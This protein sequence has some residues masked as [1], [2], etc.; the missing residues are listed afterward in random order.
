[1]QEGKDDAVNTSWNNEEDSNTGQVAV[2]RPSEQHGAGQC[3]VSS[4]VSRLPTHLSPWQMLPAVLVLVTGSYVDNLK[5]TW[6]LRAPMSILLLSFH[7]TAEETED[8]CVQTYS[9]HTTRCGK[10]GFVLSGIQ[11]EFSMGPV[12]QCHLP[13]L[14]KLES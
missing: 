14:I 12:P 5:I 9:K 11:S 6:G 13:Y 1:M 10:S 4:Q 7:P 3:G 2:N 8:Q